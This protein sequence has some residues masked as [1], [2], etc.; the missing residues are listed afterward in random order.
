MRYRVIAMSGSKSHMVLVILD[1]C[2]IVRR[3]AGR[4]ILMLSQSNMDAQPRPIV[5]PPNRRQLEVGLPDCVVVN[6]EEA[7]HVNTGADASCIRMTI[8]LDVGN[9]IARFLLLISGI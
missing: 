1:G 3:T 2:N 7:D 5:T 4:T 6:S 9:R 8:I